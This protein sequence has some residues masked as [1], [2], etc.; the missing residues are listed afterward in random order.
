MLRT[1]LDALA[2]QMCFSLSAGSRA[3]STFGLL[4]SCPAAVGIFALQATSSSASSALRFVTTGTGLAL[5]LL[6]LTLTL[7][8][9]FEFLSS[10][11]P[12]VICQHAVQLGDAAR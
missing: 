12:V 3:G 2:R 6:K 5:L 1:A 7:L 8:L 10:F 9:T 4:S 11:E